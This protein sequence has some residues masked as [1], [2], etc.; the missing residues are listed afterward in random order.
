[1]GKEKEKIRKDEKKPFEVPKLRRHEDLPV[2]T[3]G[4]INL[5]VP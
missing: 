4:S 1:M 5:N 3:A 2:I